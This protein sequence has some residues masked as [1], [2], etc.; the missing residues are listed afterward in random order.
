MR[1]EGG[2]RAPLEYIRHGGAGE[3]EACCIPHS[4][5]YYLKGSGREPPS[6][7]AWVGPIS[8]SKEKRQETGIPCLD[9]V[10]LTVRTK[11]H[12]TYSTGMRE[13]RPFEEAIFG[14]N[15]EKT[16]MASRFDFHVV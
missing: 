11:Y 1:L 12:A 9:G 16:E 4:H 14:A 2:S 3:T 13:H 10:F 15:V 7:V 6:R 8:H 5:S